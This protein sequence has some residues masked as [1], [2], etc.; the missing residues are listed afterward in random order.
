MKLHR[1]VLT[2]Y[3]GITHREIEFPDH[4]LV[5]VSGANEIGK[6]SMIEAL[7]LLLEAKDRSTKK[8]VKQVKPTHADVGAEVVA[9]IS[10]GP[11][12]FIYRKRFHRK[13]ETQLTMLAPRREQLTGDEAHERVCAL[14]AETVDTELWHAQR[15][16]Q[17]ASTAPVELSGC[18]AL[19]RALDVAAGEAVEL[20]GSE[21]LL[22]D[23]IDAEYARYFTAT[24]RPTGEWAAVT[25]RLAA[26]EDEVARC[27]AAVA[28]VDDKVRHHAVVSEQLSE[29][30][31]QR[32]P[33]S[34][35]L[36]AARVAA[37]SVA[38]MTAELKQAELV[39]AAADATHA[40]SLAALAER[41]RQRADVDERTEAVA[42]L[43]AVAAEAA[44]DQATAREV[45]DE[46]VEAA[47][48][49]QL[50]ARAAQERVD[51]AR[52]AVDRL[53]DRD[54]AH[55][56]AARLGKIDA[57]RG[58]IERAQRA[59][60][61]IVLTDELMRD[62][63]TAS[64]AVE[65]A[66]GQA[67]LASAR[68]EVT[69]LA[70]VDLRVDGQPIPLAA[71]AGWSA[72][73][74][75]ATDIELP[76]VLTAR[77]VPGIPAADTQTKLD[78]AQTLLA[79]VLARGDVADLNHARAVDRRRRNLVAARDRW[80][81]ACEGLCGDDRVDELRSR[82]AALREREPA[83]AG[84]HD[85]DLASAR[86]ELEDAAAAHVEATASCETHRK[87]AEL[88]AS[89]LAE[90]TTAATVAREK[91]AAARAE[92]IAARERLAQQRGELSDDTIASRADADGDAARV[93]TGAVAELGGRLAQA[94]PDA[95][96]AELTDAE[97]QVEA[98]ARR[99]DEVTEELREITAQLKVY[100]T[101]GRKG[102]L[103]A[104][105]TEREHAE[106]QYT[107]VRRRARAVQ[108][109]RT[110]M[111]RHRDSTRQRY[112]DP[113]RAEL[114]RLGRL[115]FGPSFEVEIDSDLCI[116]SRTLGGRTVP[117]E[118]LSGGAR[119]Q[120]GIVARLAS[121]ALVAKED[122]VPVI[123][124][125]ALGFTDAARLAKMGAVFDTVGGD[126]QVI[127]LTCSPGRYDSVAA[128]H[129]IELTA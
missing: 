116:C 40:A 109:L 88:A 104:A 114:E 59:L 129:H 4:G 91:L 7:D 100:G 17:A 10:T 6:S 97:R 83:D 50:D 14:L 54:E 53:S 68:I 103:D 119:E 35:R 101:E 74:T 120:L 111:T 62:I 8:E 24:G 41:R 15:V 108:L 39:A 93:A 5:V 126:G 71:G 32:E 33:A 113:F 76:G 80:L 34:E 94:N 121:A 105:E 22:I 96:G 29:L 122:T 65:R 43:E 47:E 72:S 85:T 2:N 128:A 26:A 45:H 46:A 42:G 110:V 69:A 37:D 98:L 70:D 64:A 77:V 51:S 60:E 90:K 3:R 106:S 127:V 125:D 84:G 28:E 75:A 118:S 20:S 117:Y 67:E 89:R 102:K 66:A 82:L 99:H 31:S 95:V 124:D 87:V 107:G 52:R 63:E 36:D 48:R 115:V 44:E 57:A 81:A 9:E 55:R 11:Y 12:R 73:A 27:A 123:I 13:C 23:R 21:P 56:L 58:E 112:V 38:A 61:A 19:S 16:L 1:L 25:A 78:A 79:D 92:L 49:T 30:A 18:D 86:A